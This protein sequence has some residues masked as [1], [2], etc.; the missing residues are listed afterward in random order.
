MVFPKTKFS[1]IDII[2]QIKNDL[3]CKEVETGYTVS[4]NWVAD[5]VGHITIGFAFTIFLSTITQYFFPGNPYGLLIALIPFSIMF[6]KEFNDYRNEKILFCQNPGILPLV[7]KDLRQYIATII[8]FVIYGI[9]VGLGSYLF[10]LYPNLFNSFLPFS[11]FFVGLIPSAF[12]THYWL[13]KKICWQRIGLPYIFRLSY[14]NKS[15]VLNENATITFLN[16]F[17]DG[18]I[19]NLI[20]SGPIRSGKTSLATGIGTELGFNQ[21]KI[22]YFTLFNFVYAIEERKN[23]KVHN[24]YILWYWQDMDIL[25][26]DDADINLLSKLNTKSYTAVVDILKTKKIIW[27]I[28]EN[29]D[30]FQ[31]LL[32]DIFSDDDVKTIKLQ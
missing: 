14:F 6:Y 19:N 13:S 7:T 24:A 20:I 25:I 30:N 5:Q 28:E 22:R 21:V 26:F 16:G 9:C 12:I 23:P 8:F 27:V 18:N 31:G 1:L 11:I 17:M 2:I 4:Y 15:R 3:W 10:A 32:Q 29:T